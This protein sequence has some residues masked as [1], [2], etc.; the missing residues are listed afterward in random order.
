VLTPATAADSALLLA[1]RNDPE[2]RRQSRSTARVP[3]A[4]H[5]RWLAATLADPEIR[6]FV[7]RDASGREVGSA[8]LDYR[9]Q[10]AAELSL[11]VAP[12][13]RGE[14]LA[15]GIIAA[16]AAEADRLGW[17]THVARIKKGNAASLKA[18]ERAGFAPDGFVHVDRRPA[19]KRARS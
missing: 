17:H 1:W 11:T 10:G 9:G 15:A 3:A 6:L 16:L 2:T 14:G 5:E 7:A 12:D 8:R 18:F 13:R 4:A 19:R